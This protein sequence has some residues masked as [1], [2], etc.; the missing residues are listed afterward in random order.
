MCKCGIVEEPTNK[1]TASLHMIGSCDL[2]WETT[3]SFESVHN[4]TPDKAYDFRQRET[5]K[6]RN[7]RKN[8]N[9]HIFQN[10]L[11]RGIQMCQTLTLVR[12]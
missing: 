3:L 2:L 10:N 7:R 9:V 5:Q 1:R 12:S 4:N 6:M 8:V 11:F